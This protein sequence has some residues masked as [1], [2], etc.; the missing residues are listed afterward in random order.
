MILVTLDTET[1]GLLPPHPTIQLAAVA[2]DG[3]MELGAFEQKI[4]FAEADADPQALALNHYS[5]EAWVNACAPGIAASRFA[6]WLRPYSDIPRVSTAG[7][8]YRVARLAA[9]NATFDVP[10]LE[11]LFGTQF[12]PW[13]R[14]VRDVLQRVLF[15]FD[16]HPDEPAPENFKLSTV[17]AY[18][19]LSADGAHDALADARLA[20][21][22]YRQM[23]REEV[24]RATD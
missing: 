3:D 24:C 10:R 6:A 20:A 23:V 22:V 11:R 15:W 13:D 19:G 18:F 21:R 9:Y 17:A 4:S 14:R 16:E 1:A 8:P 5:R 7:N 2:M 12:C